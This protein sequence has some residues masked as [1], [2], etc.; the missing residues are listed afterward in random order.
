V[1]WL[2]VV[3]VITVPAS[4]ARPGGAG[5]SIPLLMDRD[6]LQVDNSAR[7]VQ[8]KVIHCLTA[9]GTMTACFVLNGSRLEEPDSVNPY[10]RILNAGSR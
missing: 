2:I 10:C 8:V 1:A 7:A 9:R 4:S 6:A 3:V 5:Q